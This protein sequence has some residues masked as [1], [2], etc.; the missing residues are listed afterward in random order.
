ML[1]MRL[2]TLLCCSLLLQTAIAD[3]LLTAATAM[4]AG[5]YETARVLLEPK[6]QSGDTQAQYLLGSL[7]SISGEDK[8]AVT[9]LETAANGNH[10]DAATTLGK[11][12]A[13]GHGVTLDPDTAAKWFKKAGE[14]A[15]AQG[16]EE[17]ECE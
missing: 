10:H 11:M 6:A 17:P 12:F 14:I 3:D 7:Y 1:K 2:A 9:W 4:D 8:K 5:D 15:Q 13:S 16:V